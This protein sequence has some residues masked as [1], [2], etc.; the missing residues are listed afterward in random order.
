MREGCMEIAYR[1]GGDTSSGSPQN[2]TLSFTDPVASSQIDS[3]RNFATEPAEPQKYR[4]RAVSAPLRAVSSAVAA[5]EA[6][7]PAAVAGLGGAARAGAVAAVE[8]GVPGPVC[9]LGGGGHA[10]AWGGCL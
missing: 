10:R 9:G 3:T 8:A 5:V 2:Q 4:I 7:A 6:V 1:R